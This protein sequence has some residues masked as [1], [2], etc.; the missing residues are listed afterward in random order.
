[1]P[2]YDYECGDC[3]IVAEHFAGFAQTTMPCQ[4]GS[5][6]KRIISV[7][8]QYCGNQDAPWLRSVLD[9]VD[10]ESTKP[11]VRAFVQ[12][13]TR[14][15]YKRWMKGE[16]IVPMDHTEGGGPPTYLKPP[17]PDMK[18]IKKEIFEKHRARK[19]IEVR[20]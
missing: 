7:S 14:D 19:A 6:A 15:N 5:Q 17:V 16:K 4:C 8:G 3:G 20:S 13:P 10:R 18:S 11:H 2:L 1:M 12:N 9:V